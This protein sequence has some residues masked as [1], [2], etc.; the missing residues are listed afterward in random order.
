M[1]ADHISAHPRGNFLR[2]LIT[3]RYNSRETSSLAP[4]ILTHGVIHQVRTMLTVSF[5][6]SDCFAGDGV[7]GEGRSGDVV[8]RGGERSERWAGIAGKVFSSK[9]RNLVERDVRVPSGG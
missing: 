6:T 2:A 5:N 4:L 7:G 8:G 9:A 1:T 3:L